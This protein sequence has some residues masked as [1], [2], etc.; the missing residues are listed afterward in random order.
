MNEKQK[1]DKCIF[2]IFSQKK[3]EEIDAYELEQNDNLKKIEIIKKENNSEYSY[4]L[5]SL[6][7]SNNKDKSISLFLTKSNERYTALINCFK[8][9][10]KIFLYKIDFK[11]LN[12][13]LG[14]DLKQFNLS[15]KDQ[16]SIFKN[17]IVIQDNFLL[18]NL[19]LSTLDLIH[20]LSL[21]NTKGE[22]PSKIYFEFDFYLYLFINCI[23]LNNEQKNDNIIK[24]F[25]NEFHIDLIEINNSYNNN[26]S[27]KL[28]IEKITKKETLDFISDF[29]KIRN[30]ILL[31]D[32]KDESFNKKLEL[33]LAYYY[34]NYKPKV[35]INFISTK[36]ERFEDVRLN[37]TKN[38]KIFK[39]FTSDILNF[40]L[41]DEAEN[42]NELQNILLL[43]PN[44]PELIKILSIN[45]LYTKFV[46]INQIEEKACNLFEVIKPNREDNIELLSVYFYK[47]EK[48]AE[49]ES[50]IIFIMPNQLFISY[51]DF[52]YKEDLT[53]IGIIIEIY[54]EYHKIFNSKEE[55][56]EQVL[57][58]YYYET[59]LFLIHNGKIFNEDVISFID[60]VNQLSITKFEIP[61]EVYNGIILNDDTTF[62]NKLLNGLYE[63][64]TDYMNFVY[65]F[66]DKFKTL[67]DFLI[68]V[69]WDKN[70]C[71]N[72]KIFYICFDKL[73]NIWIKEK[74]KKLNVEIGDFISE[75]FVILDKKRANFISELNNLIN[76]INN[77]DVFLYIFT[78]ILK[79]KS[80]ITEQFEEFI[81]KYI[82]LNLKE[83]KPLSIYYKLFIMEKEI[84]I[85]YLVNNLKVEYAIKVEDFI[86]YPS[87]IEERI[88]LFICLYNDEYFCEK[89]N[90]ITNLEYY[91]ESINSKE[92]INTL[93]YK[94]TLNM[95]K[96][97]TDFQS[98][99]LHLL[100]NNSDTDDDY[101]FLVDSLLID[102]SEKCNKIKE[103]YNSLKLLLNYWK[104]FFNFTKRKEIN[105]LLNFLDKIEN[106]SVED[107]NKLEKK[108]NSY[109]YY[110][111][112]AQTRDRLFNSF[113]F[114]GLYKDN[115]LNFTENQ[116]E[117]KFNYALIKF[118]DLRKLG[119]NSNKENL[120]NYLKNK[121]TEL[122]YKNNDR[123]DDE[124]SLI[125]EF[126]EL[127]NK[128]NNFN[129]D[130]FKIKRAL[131]IKVNNYKILKNLD[132]YQMEFD[133]FTLIKND[134]NIVN[135]N[136]LFIINTSS[137]QNKENL[138]GFN[139]FSNEDSDN[140]E[141]TL[142]GNN[143]NEIDNTGNNK[144]NENSIKKEEKVNNINN[145][146][147]EI[148]KDIQQLSYDYY[149][150]YRINNSFD[151]FDET[152]ILL[153]QKYKN[154]FF[155]IFKNIS[156]Y[157]IDILTEKEFYEEIISTMTKLFLS[158]MGINI[159]K[160]ENNNNKEI[161][162]INEFFEVLEIY[163]K[164]HIINKSQINK[165]I[166]RFME[167][168]KYEE[169]EEKNI[170][171]SIDNLFIFISSEENL[172][173]K[174]ITNL[175]IK[176][177]V[178]EKIKN[179]N[180]GFNLKIIDF[181]MRDDYNYLLN[182]SLPI[183]DEIFKEE[184]ISKMEINNQSIL[185]NFPYFNNYSLN[186]ID[187]KCNTSKDFE[188]LIL[189][190][191]ESK[192][193]L[194]FN[195]IKN[196]MD[197]EKNLYQN[198]VINNYL[199]QSIILLE[200]GFKNELNQI[201]NKKISILF[202]IAFIKCYLNN[203]IKYLY[204]YNQ[205]IGNVDYINNDIIKG[206]KNNLFRT[207]LKLYIL[208]IFFYIFDSYKVFYQFNYES[209]QIDYF[210]NEDIENIINKNNGNKD[211][212]NKKNL[213]GF[214]YLFLPLKIEEYKNIENC[215]LNISL[216]CH[217]VNASNDLISYINNGIDLDSF[218]CVIINL[219]L[220]NY[221]NKFFFES[222]EYQ[223]IVNWLMNNINDNKLNKIN[224]LI[225]DILLIFVDNNVY[226]DKI[227]KFDNNTSYGNLSYNLL[228][229]LLLSFRIVLNTLIYSNSNNLFYQLITNS[230][231]TIESNSF[232]FNYYKNEFDSYN[233]RDINHLTFTVIRFIILSHLYFSYLLNNIKLNDI[234]TLFLNNEDNVPIMELLYKELECIKIIIK[235]KG[236]NNIIIFMNNV[237]NDIKLIIVEIQND[238]DETTMRDIE[239]NIE[240]E[241]S[242]YIENF[243]NYVEKYNDMVKEM[244]INEENNE[245]KKL[246][247]EDK[248]FYNKNLD[249][250]YPFM[251]Y[252][253]ETNFCSINDFKN[254]FYYLINDKDNYPMIN[255]ILNNLDIIKISSNLHYI[256]SFINEINNELILKIR[257]EEAEKKIFDILTENIKNKIVLFNQ[258]INE[259]NNLNSFSNNKV[260]E[261]G[262]NTKISEIINIKSNSVYKLFN[263][264]INIYNEFLINTKIYKDNKN[265]IEPLLIQ[266]ATKNDYYNLDNDVNKES[267]S[268]YDKLQENICLYSK[269]NRYKKDIL[270][271]YN[272]SKINY[273]FNQIEGILQKEFLYGKRPFKEIQR[274]FI[275]SN[276]V[277]SEERYDLIEKIKNKYPQI[278]VNDEILIKEIDTFFND[279]NM[280]N[281]NYIQIYINIQYIIIYLIMYNNNNFDSEK[282]SL[283]YI[284]QVL[285]KE[286]YII[287]E[288]FMEFL[289]LHNNNI[290]INTILYLYE[291]IE[292]KCFDNL[293][294]Q[295]SNIIINNNISVDKESKIKEY[296][297]NEKDI[298]LKEDIILNSIKKYILRYC[299]GDHTDKDDILKK[300]NIE[301]ILNKEDVW[302][303]N[304]YKN[305]QFE[306]EIKKLIN[307]N[308]EENSLMKYFLN[309]LFKNKKEKDIED[310][311]K[312]E[313]KIDKLIM[314]RIKKIR[315]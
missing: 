141:F 191:F 218:F 251:S 95:C 158:G 100:P 144:I 202:S 163:K 165:V 113:I 33:I 197:K 221:H 91:K 54:Q 198:E 166:E 286:N 53:K 205:D 289:N 216:N 119:Y 74:D 299:I 10:P 92:K 78:S 196:N 22:A 224:N 288:L 106:T 297:N 68:L 195:K 296:F 56:I 50:F 142:F 160:K 38:R 204:R 148:L 121:I 276:E 254:Q 114:M 49:E 86:N 85:P 116:E 134:D 237:F 284:A 37:L 129:F 222:N 112:E 309:I 178:Q 168:K 105:E 60:K 235:L 135:N 147:K 137:N 270:N 52:F 313:D 31:I 73:K 159:S 40:N 307:L 239:S 77:S 110:I 25:F 260:K 89:Y 65:S 292:L 252:L 238:N 215:L 290:H 84:R 111:N 258:K 293:T 29:N 249:K 98:L 184:I 280:T 269:R 271:V 157:D 48:I 273:D 4:I 109:L 87:V 107:Y 3:D 66:F 115:S 63:K 108:I 173:K 102:F 146:K 272:G 225:K 9:Y 171:N 233:Y 306:E 300:I 203:Y 308:D 186:Q 81:N 79:K 127:E 230:K 209:F 36:N 244:R 28:L 42:F 15:Y 150:I 58:Q 312:N 80:L 295:I 131:T 153:I 217:N 14:I 294:E 83:G 255:C 212:Y 277:F 190:Y 243:D 71:S 8:I 156:K 268:A 139:L 182:D 169:G 265:L 93:K 6:H 298:L 181:I 175:L 285:Q 287:N 123:L 267:I 120:S 151:L 245:F 256:N 278:E 167:L 234:N 246:I 201:N 207:T 192:L 176:L 75:L 62:I 143:D 253:T 125:K 259:L 149:Y 247:T 59:G 138:N 57:F 94:D 303:T 132:D 27:N 188:E 104:H 128:E 70:N 314:K 301:K 219:L 304:I 130:I 145:E 179:E 61:S 5:Y 18:K 55:D 228:L 39:D 101:D 154:F 213:Y 164:Y 30:K 180:E 281:N 24:Y 250:N 257:K 200:K 177:I 133:D 302:S 43:V 13:N 88:S 23:T 122:I 17:M 140:D 82:S 44:L 315:Y 264:I 183:L 90:N 21:I 64:Y 199:N 227:L 99:F 7:L 1:R 223:N 248:Y 305:E 117:D 96:N 46:L 187:K 310:K 97:I 103:Q 118:N 226:K 51:C 241:I 172:Q 274:T 211:I 208:K 32:D 69:K 282:I 236:I 12:N 155:E 136:N 229:T 291:K 20:N 11:P 266:S 35:F 45:E 214:D 47:L 206:D 19:C 76:N 283:G 263:K 189:Y 162:L 242:K 311:E 232:Y 262:I 185:N 124:L 16:F 174:A 194:I 210:K 72:D 170:I 240:N 126:F 261:I 41:L 193:T 275:F 67:K 231:N 26:S 152:S 161:Y 2:F 220:S 279:Q 34:I